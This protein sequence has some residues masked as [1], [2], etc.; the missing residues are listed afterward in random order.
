MKHPRI[1]S[2]MRARAHRKMAFSALKSDSS[3]SV[4]LHR[5]SRHMAKAYA[6]ETQEVAS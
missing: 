6:L 4:R 1:A 5:Y 3:L 2:T